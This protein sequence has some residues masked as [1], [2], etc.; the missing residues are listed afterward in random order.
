[1]NSVSIT[2]SVCPTDGIVKVRLKKN[3]EVSQWYN[4]PYKGISDP[5]ITSTAAYQFEYSTL[6]LDVASSS[7]SKLHGPERVYMWHQGK[8]QLPLK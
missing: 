6:A 1:M 8:E 2:S 5:A 7:L 3:G 4:C